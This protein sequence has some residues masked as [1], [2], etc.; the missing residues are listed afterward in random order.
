MPHSHMW[1]VV[2]TTLVVHVELSVLEEGY[3]KEATI[4]KSGYPRQPKRHR[5]ERWEQAF[6]AFFVLPRFL[7]VPQA[8]H[9]TTALGTS[10]CTLSESMEGGGGGFMQD[11]YR[12]PIN[13]CTA[14][15]LDKSCIGTSHPSSLHST[16]SISLALVSPLLNPHDILYSTPP[17]PCTRRAR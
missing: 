11:Q 5:G 10:P 13:R 2:K 17:C 14:F 16:H 6:F 1:L 8:H 7:I 4:N 12:P 15:R 9:H 3:A